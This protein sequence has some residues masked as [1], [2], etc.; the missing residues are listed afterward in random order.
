[1]SR[2]VMRCVASVVRGGRSKVL[3]SHVV[4]TEAQPVT[5]LD[6]LPRDIRDANESFSVILAR[7]L[8]TAQE[9]AARRV[10]VVRAPM[11]RALFAFYSEHNH[12]YRGTTWDDEAAHRLDATQEHNVV[13]DA[14]RD[15]AVAGVAARADEEAGNIR[16]APDADAAANAAEEQLVRGDGSVIVD[17][18]PGG[19]GRAAA[20]AA[21]VVVVREQGALLTDA[22]AYSYALLFP[23]L[24]PF[25][26]AVSASLLRYNHASRAAARCGELAIRRRLRLRKSRLARRACFLGALRPQ[27]RP[28]GAALRSDVLSHARVHSRA[29]R[30]FPAPGVRAT[31]SARRLLPRAAS[32]G[33]RVAR[34]LH[35]TPSRRTH[36]C[37]A[38]GACT[39]DHGVQVPR[40]DAGWRDRGSVARSRWWFRAARCFVCGLVS[41]SHMCCHSIVVLFESK[42]WRTS[43]RRKMC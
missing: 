6:R 35:R 24:F 22:T 39:C 15:S 31:T 12:L 7:P 21:G 20:Q 11:L 25:G 40:P 19:Q 33:Q 32:V 37:T 23:H 5:L 1:M 28:C 17:V 29:R 2:A 9:L 8:T 30:T 10:A 16:R 4:V 3:K 18:N 36:V 43:R 13:E 41:C 26:L 34:L 38:F 27:R 14:P 42:T